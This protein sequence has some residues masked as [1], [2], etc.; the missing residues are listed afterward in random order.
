M[1]QKLE[2]DTFTIDN[3]NI[4]CVKFFFQTYRIEYKTT[5]R[6]CEEIFHKTCQWCAPVLRHDFSLLSA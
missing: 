1:N 2:S 3:L 6:M 4:N 5:A